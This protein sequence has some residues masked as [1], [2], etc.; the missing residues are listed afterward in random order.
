LNL[1]TDR[2]RER[3]RKRERER[4]TPVIKDRTGLAR[5]SSGEWVNRS[6]RRV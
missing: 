4:E 1:E 3:E 2:E 5:H 6:A